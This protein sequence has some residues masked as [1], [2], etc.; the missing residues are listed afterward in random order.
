MA[1]LT[2]E[3]RRDQILKAAITVSE[4]M[5]YQAVRREDIAEEAQV[6][7]GS[8]SRYFG[9]M[10]QMRKAIVVNA[11]ATRNLKIIAQGLAALDTHAL[12]APKALKKAAY[13]FAMKN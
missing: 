4:A 1:R 10:S 3:I 6:S 13:E 8:V 9:T 7:P 2:P 11:I 5:G 12:K